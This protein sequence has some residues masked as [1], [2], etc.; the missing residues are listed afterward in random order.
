MQKHSLKAEKRKVLGR[1]V[2]SLRREGILPANIYGA[3]IKSEAVQ[4]EK[5][6]FQKVF[7][8]AGE[9]GLVEVNLGKATRPVLIANVQT[10]PVTDE[11]VHV[12]LLQV[13]LKK[14]V[15][16]QVPLE[17]VG[18]SPAEKSGLGTVVTQLTEIEVEALPTDLPEKFEVDLS[19][20]T[21]V[22]QA[23]YVKDLA[24]EKD[25]V[26]LEADDQQIVAKVEPPQKEEEVTPPPAEEVTEEEEAPAEGE[27]AEK[28]EKEEEE[29]GEAKEEGTKEKATED[30]KSA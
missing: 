5:G 23:V 16:A 1:K 3:G 24:Y 2:K 28:A 27:V 10:D 7:A 11:P 6:V 20:L 15:T 13:D 30:Q 4:L 14:K 26:K 8:A 12:D 18:E 25:K 19:N 29:K 17:F 22:D 21:E 9:T